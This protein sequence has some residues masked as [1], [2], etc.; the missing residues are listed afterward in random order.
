M[1]ETVQMK[2]LCDHTVAMQGDTLFTQSEIG[3]RVKNE[4]YSWTSHSKTMAS[5]KGEPDKAETF[6]PLHFLDRRRGYMTLFNNCPFCGEKIN[7]KAIKDEVCHSDV[8]A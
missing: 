7:W 3:E 4:A 5:L 6:E 8:D 1:S 2:T